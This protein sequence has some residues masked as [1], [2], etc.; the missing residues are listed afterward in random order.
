M[1][2]ERG[3]GD[4]GHVFVHVSQHFS[5]PSPLSPKLLAQISFSTPPTILSLAALFFAQVEQ[6]VLSLNNLNGCFLSFLAKGS[7]TFLLG[8]PKGSG[9]P[10]LPV[11]HLGISPECGDAVLTTSTCGEA[12]TDMPDTCYT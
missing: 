3:L 2:L 11:T 1:G 5:G 12:Q 4:S 8:L 9:F 10:G 6:D 7:G